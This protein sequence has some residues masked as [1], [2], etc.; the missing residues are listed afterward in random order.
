M[1]WILC[2][3]LLAFAVKLIIASNTFGTNDVV[4]FYEF[5]KSLHQHGL[6]WTYENDIS[7]NHPP[8]TAYY[9]NAIYQLDHRV[10]FREHGLTFPFLIRLPGIIADLITLFALLWLTRQDKRIRIPSWALIL[11]AFSPVSVMVTGFHGNTDPVMV[12]FLVF[13]AI[14]TVRFK[15]ALA[16]LMLALSCQIKIVPLLL[17][18]VFFFFWNARGKTLSFTLPF[19]ITSALLWIEPLTRFPS[20]FIRNVLSYGS[21]WGIWG[22]TYWLRLTN[23][24]QLGLVTSHDFPPW[25]NFIVTFLKI[26]II[27]AVFMIAWRRRKLDE[28]AFLNSIACVWMVFFIFSPGVCVQYMVWLAPFVLFLSPTFYAWLAASSSLFVFFFYNV[29]AGGL[30]WYVA[31]STNRLNRIWTPW[32]VWPW[33]VLMLGLLVMWRDATAKDRSLR[34]V[35]LREVV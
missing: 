5:G 1:F 31:I 14:F 28:N 22:I 10:F 30:P 9:L 27:C 15:P 35:S 17:L 11:F 25:E 21:F 4:A 18:P 24:P 13:A 23:F 8:V 34:L 2:A 26:F 6:Q 33:I 20:F 29:T 12:M 16:G 32:T 3:G 19:I 7:F